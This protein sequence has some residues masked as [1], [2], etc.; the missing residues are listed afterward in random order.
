VINELK[1]SWRGEYEITEAIAKMV[2]KGLEV[3]YN[4]LQGR[5]FDAGTFDDILDASVFM[6]EKMRGR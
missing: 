4:I 3:K 6:K 5:W 2:A 1:P